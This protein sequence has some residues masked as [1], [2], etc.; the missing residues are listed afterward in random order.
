MN[1]IQEQERLLDVK[2]IEK[3]IFSLKQSFL[4]AEIT[5]TLNIYHI[6]HCRPNSVYPA[7]QQGWGIGHK[8]IKWINYK[9]NKVGKTKSDVTKV[10]KINYT[11]I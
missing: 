4:P 9:P 6:H 3:I 2:L 8:S 7:I 5:K 1:E 10:S 11:E